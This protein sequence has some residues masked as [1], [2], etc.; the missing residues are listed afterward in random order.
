MG[1][2]GER[3][4]P[5]R[6]EAQWMRRAEWEEVIRDRWSMS[7]GADHFEQLFNGV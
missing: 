4:R 1:V 3:R 2:G 5:F 6:F 7:G